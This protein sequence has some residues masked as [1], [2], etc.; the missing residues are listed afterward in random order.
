MRVSIKVYSSCARVARKVI[1]RGCEIGGSRSNEITRTKSIAGIRR[2]ENASRLLF[3]HRRSE[4]KPIKWTGLN[5][6][7][8]VLFFSRFLARMRNGRKRAIES[9]DKTLSGV[10]GRQVILYCGPGTC[11]GLLLT[12]TTP[13]YEPRTA[14]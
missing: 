7:D 3:S 10:S 9:P 6:I 14:P 2:L 13:P 11:N 8:F 4:I 5:N 1:S 12:T